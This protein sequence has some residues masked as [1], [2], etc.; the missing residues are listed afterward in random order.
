MFTHSA[1]RRRPFERALSLLGIMQRGRTKRLRS[2]RTAASIA[3]AAEL[4]EDRTLLSG[5]TLITH[6]F[7]FGFSTGCSPESNP[8]WLDTMGQEVA[9]R[10]SQ[11]YGGDYGLADV[12]Q[13]HI[14]ICSDGNTI[15]HTAGS[16]TADAANTGEVVVTVD[17][18]D[19]ANI[20][21]YIPTGSV[22]EGLFNTLDSTYTG[23]GISQPLAELP[24]HLIG[25][26]RGGSVIGALANDLGETGLYVDHTTYLDTHPIGVDWGWFGD[27]PVTENV[28]FAESYWRDDGLLPPFNILD[29][30]GKV[31]DGAYDNELT[32]GLSYEYFLDAPLPSTDGDGY[33]QEH[34]DVHL[35]YH[36][37][38]DTTDPAC[39]GDDGEGKC[40]PTARD[41]YDGVIGPGPRQNTGYAY[42]RVIGEDRPSVGIA[43]DISGSAEQNRIEVALTG[44][45]WPNVLLLNVDADDL[46]T[47][48]GVPIDVS[49]YYHD[50]D[51]TATVT[52]FL[53]TDR[54]PYT[55]G[56]QYDDANQV[57]YFVPTEKVQFDDSQQIA[58]GS[59]FPRIYN[60]GAR[61]TDIDGFTRY[62]YA[63][64]QVTIS[65]TVNVEPDPGNPN[66]DD[67]MTIAVNPDNAALVDIT[68][69]GE[70]E[71]VAAALLEGIDINGGGGDDTLNL[72]FSNG[73]PIPAG[74]LTFNGGGGNDDLNVNAGD[75]AAT[76]GFTRTA[77]AGS[78]TV[79]G[80]TIDFTG[81]EPST[82]TLTGTT[83]VT[84]DLT[85]GDTVN[86]TRVSATRSRATGQSNAVEFDNP[87]TQLIINAQDSNDYTLNFTDLADSFNPSSGIDINGNSGQE[88]VTITDLGDTFGNGNT[89]TLDIDLVGGSDSVTFQT[90]TQSL[91]ALS[92]T[93]ET[94]N[95]A[96]ALDVSGTATINNEGSTSALNLNHAN[97]DFGTV[98]ITAANAGVTVRD[99][100][101]LN[102]GNTTA[103][104]LD[105]DAGGAITDT[106]GVTLSVTNNAD[107]NGSSITLGDNAG[108]TVN[109]G[110]LTFN[111]GGAVSVDEDSATLITGTNTAGSLD[112]NSAS[113]ITDAAATILNV[114]NNADFNSTSITLGDD[115]GDTTNFGSLTFTSGAVE[116]TEDSG[117]AFEATSSG[118]V[119]TVNSAGTMSD[120][121]ADP[122]NEITGD[123]LI[124]TADG[125][126]GLAGAYIDVAVTRLDVSN[127]DSHNTGYGIFIEGTGGGLELTDLGGPNTNAV[128]GFGG[129][130][131]IIASSPLTITSDAVTTGGMTYTAAD[132]PGVGDDLTVSNLLSNITVQDTTDDLTLNAGD[133]L[134]INIDTHVLAT[135]TLDLNIDAGNADVG[136][137]ATA[138]I[139]GEVQGT[140]GGITATGDSDDDIFNI[141]DNG[142]GLL[143][144][145]DD[146]GSVDIV[147][148]DITVNGNGGITNTLNLDDSGETVNQV[149]S[150][151][152]SG[153]ASGTIGDGGTDNY[154]DDVVG[155]GPAL[156]FADIQQVN[157]RTGRDVTDD[158]T[159]LINVQPNKGTAFDI[160]GN[161]PEFP[162]AATPNVDELHY[163]ATGI[164][165]ETFATN[166][167][168]A[169]GLGD[170]TFN[171][172]YQA[173][174]YNSIEWHTGPQH[175]EIDASTLGIAGNEQDDTYTV[176]AVGS[177]VLINVVD[178]S[179]ASLPGDLGY[180]QEIDVLSITVTGS[181]DDDD[182][183]INDGSSG[184]LPQTQSVLPAVDLLNRDPVDDETNNVWVVDPTPD[185]LG[186]GAVE[187]PGFMFLAGVGSDSIVLN[188]TQGV[189]T[190]VTYAMGEGD[191]GGSN[192][193]DDGAEGE[194]L[195]ENAAE[196]LNIYFT[197]L[198]PITVNG[199]PGGTLTIIG[200]TDANTINVIDGTSV[201][202]PGYTQINGINTLGAFET[203]DFA[204]DSFLALEIYGHDGSDTIDVQNFEEDEDTLATIVIDGDSQ[205][206]SD[207]S[208]DTLIVRTTNDVPNTSVLT[209]RG[210]VGDDRFYLDFL[211]A[212]I[213]TGT[214][215]G[216][217]AQV[218][219][220]GAGDE[221]D[222]NDLLRI[223]DFGDLE[224]GGDTVNVTSTTVDGITG[225]GLATLDV[226]YVLGTGTETVQII[227]GDNAGDTV[228]IQSTD[229]DATYWIETHGGGDTVNIS[230]DAPTN[231]GILNDINGQVNLATGADEDRLNISDYGDT[232]GDNYVLD[233]FGVFPNEWTTLT[234]DDGAQAVD[235]RYDME[236]DDVLAAGENPTGETLEHFLLEGAND[237]L[238]PLVGNLDTYTINDTSGTVSN[239]INDGREDL[240][241]SNFDNSRFTIL[242]DNVQEEATN[243]FRGFEGTDVFW[244]RFA[245]DGGVPTDVGTTFV[246]DGGTQDTSDRTRRDRVEMD[247]TSD[248][249]ARNAAGGGITVLYADSTSGDVDVTGYGTPTVIELNRVE[250]VAFEGGGDDDTVTV[251]GTT[252]SDILSVTP[253][254]SDEAAVYIGGNPFLKHDPAGTPNQSAVDNDPGYAH[255]AAT[256]G[257]VGIGPDLIFDDIDSLTVNGDDGSVGMGD[258]DR[259]VINAPT[260]SNAAVDLTENTSGF[261]G[262]TLAT[263]ASTDFNAN[264]QAQVSTDPG[265]T[266]AAPAS[267]V[268]ADGLAFDDITVTDTAV[269]IVLKGDGSATDSLIT[270]NF[271]NTTYNVVDPQHAELTV[272]SGEEAGLRTEPDPAVPAPDPDED[273]L[274][275]DITVT[276]SRTF[277]FQING[278]EP[279]LPADA[280]TAAAAEALVGDRLNVDVLNTDGNINVY[281]DLEDSPNV[282]ISSTDSIGTTEPVTYYNVELTVLDPGDLSRQ[283]NV[284]GDNNEFGGVDQDDEILVLG[285]DIDRLFTNPPHAGT[286]DIDGANEFYL[287]LNGS[288]P[289]L[290][291]NV[292]YLNISGSAGDD[293]VTIEPYANDLTG[294]WNIDVAVDG[295]AGDD[296]L[297]YGSAERD[298]VTQPG[299]QFVDDTPDGSISGVSE[300]VMI[301]PTSVAGAGQVR[302]VNATDSTNIVTIDFTNTE[303]ISVY[304][305]DGSSGDNDSLTVLATAGDDVVDINLSNAGDDAEPLLNIT[306]QLQ[307][308]D[309]KAATADS[310]PSAGN[311]S[312]MLNSISDVAIATGD[313]DDIV[314]ATGGSGPIE[315]SISTG[316]SLDSITVTPSAGTIFNID[317]GG[318]GVGDLL[319]VVDS[320]GGS[321]ID[322]RLG[323]NPNSGSITVAGSD[324]VWYEDVERLAVPLITNP[325]LVVLKADGYEPNDTLAT[326]WY[327]GSGDV[328]NVDPVIDPAGDVD[329]FAVLTRETGT[330]DFQV[331]F[332]HADG[333]LNIEVVDADGDLVASGSSTTDSERVTIGAIQDETYLLRVFGAT[334]TEINGYAFSIINTA[335]PLPL[336]VD[337]QSGSDTG[338]N[339]ADNTTSDTAAVFD[340]YLDDD[341][342][343]EFVNLDLLPDTDFDVQVFN[344]GEL[345]GEASYQSESRWEFTASPGD[346]QE[347]HNNF[348]TAAVLIRDR[349]N[350][351]AIGRGALSESLLVTLDTAA[352]AAPSLGIDPTGTDTGVAG[353]PVTLSDRITADST[354]GFVGTA[355]ANANVRLL[356]DGVAIGQGVA[357][358]SDGDESEAA[359]QWGIA[360]T[361]DLNNSG[362]FALDGAR[363]ITATAED[364]AG[365]VS[366][367]ASLDI[368]IDSQGP[369]VTDVQFNSTT[370][371][372][373]VF[374]P[375]RTTPAVTSLVVSI[376]D[377]ANRSGTFLHDALVQGIA[378]DRGQYRLVGDH[379]GAI[380]I[381]DVTVAQNSLDSN[382]ATATITLA[383]NG[384]LPDDRYTLTL[385]D[386]LTDPA[387]NSLD[388]ESNAAEPQATPSFATG[389][390]QPGGDFVAR[391]TVDSR[392][393]VAAVGQAGIAVD[394]NDNMSHDPSS[395][396]AVHRD[397][398]FLVGE[399]TDALF[400][401]QFSDG[402]TNDGFD[403]LGAYGRV[404]G[405]YR[406]LLDTDN[407]GV[408]DV[409]NVGLQVD[410]FPVAGNFDTGRA[411]DEIGLYD[412]STWYF[413]TDGDNSIGAGDAAPLTGD[414]YGIPIVGDF[415]GDGSDD[416]AVYRPVSNTFFFDLT[417]AADGTPGVRDGAADTSISFFGFP[418]V[419]ERPFAGDY[420]LDGVD[421]IGLTVPNQSGN[422]P[423]DTLEWYFLVS[424]RAVATPGTVDAWDTGFSPVPLGND[425]YGQFGNNLSIPLFGNFD[426]PV[427]Q[428]QQ[429]AGQSDFDPATGQLVVTL[430]QAASVELTNSGGTIDVLIDGQ[431]DS[432]LGTVLTRN[433]SSLVVNG[434]N[435]ND[436]IDLSAVTHSAYDRLENVSVFAGDGN[437]IIIGSGLND[438]IWAGRGNDY[439][440]AGEGDD[441]IN[442]QAGNDVV[443]AGPGRDRMLGGGGHDELDGGDGDDFAQG[444]AGDDILRGGNGNDRLNGSGGHDQLIGQDGNDRL[445]G[446]AGRDRIDGGSG[447]DFLNGQGGADE[448]FGGDGA[449]RIKGGIGHDRLD[450]GSGD[451]RLM[452]QN[453]DDVLLGGLGNDILR[454]QDGADQ[455][456]GGAGDDLLNGG[457][458]FDRIMETND[459]DFLLSDTILIGLGIDRLVG[460]DGA[461]LI[462]GSGD[463]TLDARGFSGSTVLV[464]QAGN[465][466]LYGG[467]GADILRGNAG[468]DVLDGGAG[469]D[470]LFGGAGNDMAFGGLGDDIVNGQGGSND[471]LAGGEGDD[472]VIGVASEID[473]SF[474]F[475]A[476]WVDAV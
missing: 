420:N 295:G 12:A 327:L 107:F 248:L 118:T 258:E 132:S 352:P 158:L 392:P 182:L 112:L 103:N 259:L 305:N 187:G 21:P 463:N 334:G 128:N 94:V 374:N 422:T 287:L 23:I 306:G 111:S 473:E 447:N 313:G 62:A 140:T 308:E 326:A 245:A 466:R 439:V 123:D 404:G 32:F 191:G 3:S 217:L 476:E 149:V 90:N 356:S 43:A 115:A 265:T 146:G 86:F 200:D 267:T 57:T 474:A 354:P 193:D 221:T 304:F 96:A 467:I 338:R 161:L 194:L 333:D 180:W 288:N 229:I 331:S 281:S 293:D 144:D 46:E 104:S 341:R 84:L 136:V 318:P 366:A 39:D 261:G 379:G 212:A 113:T 61:I 160:D 430:S 100:N 396:D 13:Y 224:V 109:F 257:N 298:A 225:N 65:G 49:Y 44:D 231:D 91:A 166:T 342:F 108:D 79:N 411:G 375:Q 30:D 97:N 72:D 174:H 167:P 40:V 249:L 138:N 77:G 76:F 367:V 192:T 302:S 213:R 409:T 205:G 343:E 353:Q 171:N 410:G 236:D 314:T 435:G 378:E 185:S 237:Q 197:G 121:E 139:N 4:L 28:V 53:D 296:D 22:A 7:L 407:D 211:P 42:S 38:I 376:Q 9:N 397:L 59:L 152:R 186:L 377:L 124:L 240:S 34:S 368:F 264:W 350:P 19:V 316:A 290:M 382:P 142:D 52:F 117:T 282:S 1:S 371:S 181:G 339:D 156:T 358:P 451:D 222:G 361:V 252:D 105:V 441:W 403:R 155:T 445:L 102:L 8:T 196:N 11:E 120:F 370:S 425:R 292:Q 426:P 50:Q 383:L 37:T 29:F 31:V 198:E 299:M 448:L 450:G 286:P 71:T 437:D 348:L 402:V 119:I 423:H 18:S 25:H 93:T 250:Q 175:V 195:V 349:A 16:P 443:H 432:S 363:L 129:N 27:F 131:E 461:T 232:D 227:T 401:G 262:F 332:A 284:I 177:D 207:S 164:D 468:D 405:I 75:Q 270:V 133:D 421:D 165:A 204:V 78:V 134:H 137:G 277:H 170:L 67:V 60:I 184:G 340:I 419:L 69:N 438:T 449:D 275:D 372:Y 323:L 315:V 54:N 99:T 230:S 278:G 14:E 242:A 106:S 157:L 153:M 433:L 472:Q 82:I 459:G 307:V 464:G 399:Q 163:D 247:A 301:A 279:P 150:I 329:V 428:G 172:G 417:S 408:T 317:G 330:L 274:A 434:S 395:G 6:G 283:V 359:G 389:D 58:T 215:D 36:G 413:D 188:L 159:D 400:A 465:D 179:L 460:M 85:G 116:I 253:L 384:F 380:T 321:R 271:D 241:T 151:T 336:Q 280:P 436:T 364:L 440:Q 63:P 357:S 162:A 98:V 206:N 89:G 256:G 471:T 455:L 309:F 26:S 387:G 289:I 414:L 239:D 199:T 51:S 80:S 442:A 45:A 335:A 235:I 148:S 66:A 416:L 276:L 145:N 168:T 285:G 347:G 393:E 385:A 219:V 233:Q 469:N 101:G 130:G 470:Q 311:L 319:D 355:E 74:G 303:D 122:D 127:V 412:Q 228:N 33:S 135:T 64:Q 226:T 328:I 291:Y 15:S 47:T 216:I 381:S 324:P 268:R 456:S 373:N 462:G 24:I 390:G 394:I 35:W 458:G 209:M 310:R 55:T 141:D 244:V 346:L 325:N 246:I 444:N 143:P 294:N 178:A 87:T 312:P 190:S 254:T 56:G 125:G 5:V 189:T 251:Q 126:V 2:R 406:W 208:D 48:I 41:W 183:V 243:T 17:W 169:A 110:S 351:Q 88:T 297:I 154:F 202:A 92:L 365:N 427:T 210:G 344:N 218:V 454:G 223:D 429:L 263:T 362:F 260:E 320:V 273:L 201:G 176:T 238:T 203:L 234:F 475:W 266:M 10:I 424:D 452:G 457:R 369:Q 300:V 70:T 418:G 360:G 173:V 114:T 68:I 20:F 415:D 391:F 453:G 220:S 73:N 147:L 388:G 272:N 83:S 95:N 269:S 322:H 337:L 81:V 446:G 386:S 398:N 345:L 431:V 255:D 214:V